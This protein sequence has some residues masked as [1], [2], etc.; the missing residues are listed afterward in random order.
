MPD[1]SGDSSFFALIPAEMMERLG[2]AFF[3][4]FIMI[5][6]GSYIAPKG[7]FE[8]GIVMA[9]LWGVAI[10]ASLVI[11]QSRW[12]YEAW[13]LLR[14]GLAVLIG[15]AGVSVGLIQS[16]KLSRPTLTTL[17]KAPQPS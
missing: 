1:G 17:Q 16:Q 13:G 15:I 11:V 14:I 8:T 9:V 6:T 7:K 12:N 5:Y 3:T 4:P 2:Y 10:G